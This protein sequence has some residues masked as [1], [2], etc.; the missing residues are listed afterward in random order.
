MD[1]SLHEMLGVRY[2]YY[3][4]VKM[5]VYGLLRLGDMVTYSTSPQSQVEYRMMGEIELGAF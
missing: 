1:T 2:D 5:L 3:K 4:D